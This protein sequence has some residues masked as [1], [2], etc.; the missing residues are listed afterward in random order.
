M[1]EYDNGVAK[2]KQHLDL[3]ISALPVARHGLGRR[4][5]IFQHSS[6]AVQLL[7]SAA[8]TTREHASAGRL[9]E[10]SDPQRQSC[11][12]LPILHVA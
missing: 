9:Q 7:R 1:P 11:H 2:L 4:L 8:D 10:L 5:L 12:A 6:Y 3:L